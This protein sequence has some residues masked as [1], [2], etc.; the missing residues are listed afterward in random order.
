MMKDKNYCTI[1]PLLTSLNQLSFSLLKVQNHVSLC[2]LS[3][4][5][6]EQHQPILETL[7]QSR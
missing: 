7:V 1:I 3:L 5:P 4:L 2:I 6:K